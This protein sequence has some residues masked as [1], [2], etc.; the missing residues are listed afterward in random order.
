MEVDSAPPAVPKAPEVK[1][2]AAVPLAREGAA[3]PPPPTIPAAK[4]PSPSKG[5]TRGRSP[6]RAPRAAKGASVPGS[7]ES[8]DRIAARQQYLKETKSDDAETAGAHSRAVV[9]IFQQKSKMERHLAAIAEE[10]ALE[11]EM[12]V[13]V[14]EKKRSTPPKPKKS[15]QSA[16]S[17]GKR[18]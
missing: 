7:A 3:K 17:S 11:M 13:V 8:K 1:A 6:E 5:K 12:P 10:K 4:A 18:G 2:T 15:E 14:S 9:N 16:S